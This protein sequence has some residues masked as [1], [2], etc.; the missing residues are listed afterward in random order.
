MVYCYSGSCFVDNANI[1][2]LRN[3]Y[4]VCFSSVHCSVMGTGL[5]VEELWTPGGG[6]ELCYGRMYTGC[7]YGWI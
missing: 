6:T 3:V 1:H 7:S 5:V 4:C 2:Y